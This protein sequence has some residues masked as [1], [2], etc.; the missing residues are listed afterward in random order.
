M[1]ILSYTLTSADNGTSLPLADAYLINLSMTVPPV[2]DDGFDPVT[3]QYKNALLSIAD[4]GPTPLYYADMR[5]NPL[6]AGTSSQGGSMVILKNANRPY[7]GSLHI[8]SIPYGATFTID[9][10]DAP[11]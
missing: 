10:S 9:V 5:S 11:V 6:S 2:T 8:N 4:D 1:A 3:G 7:T